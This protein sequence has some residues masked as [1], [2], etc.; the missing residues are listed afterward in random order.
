MKLKYLLLFKNILHNWTEG[1]D[2]LVS[3]NNKKL[4][5]IELAV[6]QFSEKVSALNREKSL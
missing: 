5:Y 3:K 2:L 1:T 6:V 4:S